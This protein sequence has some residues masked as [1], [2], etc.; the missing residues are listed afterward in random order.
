MGLGMPRN[1]WV[2]GQPT[3]ES[4][5]LKRPAEMLCGLRV[6][7]LYRFISDYQTEHKFLPDDMRVNVLP[8]KP[9]DEFRARGIWQRVLR[10]FFFFWRGVD[11]SA[12]GC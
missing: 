4:R 12:F 11:L 9:A 7:L 1:E 3:H 6:L 10:F 8:E 5:R 2:L